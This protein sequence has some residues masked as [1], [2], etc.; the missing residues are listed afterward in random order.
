MEEHQRGKKQ[1]NLHNSPDVSGF[2][3]LIDNDF[4]KVGA[5]GNHETAK[6]RQQ[7]PFPD[8]IPLGPGK[9]ENAPGLT[10]VFMHTGPLKLFLTHL[11]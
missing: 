4:K 6:D 9:T 7:H 2:D 8:P 5:G 11:P 1:A 10:V 3:M